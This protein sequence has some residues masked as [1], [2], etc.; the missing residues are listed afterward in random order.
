MSI[1]SQAVLSMH[2]DP[3]EA[4]TEACNALEALVGI[5]PMSIWVSRLPVDLSKLCELRQYDR[6]EWIVSKA[7]DRVQAGGGLLE[8]IP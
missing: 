2:Q 3:R 5:V 7:I 8:Q 4:L 6:A 1:K